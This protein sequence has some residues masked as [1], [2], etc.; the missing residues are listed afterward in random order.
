MV[1]MVVMMLTMMMLMM[2]ALIVTIFQNANIII[3]EVA[4]HDQQHVKYPKLYKKLQ[5]TT[6]DTH[7]QIFTTDIQQIP[8]RKA[9]MLVMTQIHINK[10]LKNP[11]MLT[12]GKHQNSCCQQKLVTNND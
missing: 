4:T 12:T 2:M 7:Q 5:I 6:Q 9:D 3:G 1:A 11:Y 8:F 10:T